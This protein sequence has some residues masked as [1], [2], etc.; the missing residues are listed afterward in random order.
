MYGGGRP[1]IIIVGFDDR[2]VVLSRYR[3]AERTFFS[4][5]KEEFLLLLLY[6]YV[7]GSSADVG[8]DF[9]GAFVD[10]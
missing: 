7:I 5:K 6:C 1:L 9:D 10:R 8:S 3:P 2:L 4:L